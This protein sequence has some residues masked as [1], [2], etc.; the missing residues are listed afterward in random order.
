MKEKLEKASQGDAAAYP[1]LEK[2]GRENIRPGCKY[3][4]VTLL[5][6]WL[7]TKDQGKDASDRRFIWTERGNE[8]ICKDHQTLELQKPL[9]ARVTSVTTDI[10]LPTLE[11][12]DA[13]AFGNIA[14]W[15]FL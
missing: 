11:V 3:Q 8:E 5:E 7:I 15:L 14:L 1:H 13:A 12:F 4:Q 6:G 2:A 9:E 10:S